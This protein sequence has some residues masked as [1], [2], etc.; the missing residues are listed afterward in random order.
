MNFFQRLKQ[1]KVR[2]R[3]D[4]ALTIYVAAYTYGHLSTT[5][6][7]R[8]AD[9]IKNLIDGG[10]LPAFSF[11]EFKLFMQV[12]AKAAFWAVAMKSLGIP[13]SIPGEV[14][15][16]PAQP[17]WGSRFS[18]VNKLLGNWRLIGPTTTEAENYL[19]SKGIDVTSIDL[20]AR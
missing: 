11:M 20:H 2:R 8:V 13:P 6:Q 14:W 12:K 18:V 4:A 1:R 15:Q 5:D 16:I 7:K 19:I 17:R 9:W 3:Y 10:F